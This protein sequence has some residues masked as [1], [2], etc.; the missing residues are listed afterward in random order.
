MRQNRYEGGST[1]QQRTALETVERAARDRLNRMRMHANQPAIRDSEKIPMLYVVLEALRHAQEPMRTHA[2]RA[3]EH[4][5]V[6]FCVSMPIKVLFA[7]TLTTLNPWDNSPKPV[8]IVIAAIRQISTWK[9]ADE[10]DL[11]N[12]G[13]LEYKKLD[14]NKRPKISH[15]PF[16]QR[17]VEK[18]DVLDGVIDSYNVTVD[19]HW[20]DGDV[21]VDFSPELDDQ[22]EWNSSDESTVVQTPQENMFGPQS[23]PN[24]ISSLDIE[25]AGTTTNELAPPVGDGGLTGR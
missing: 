9:F 18:V 21:T 12:L 23:D 1:G 13:I 14:K 25:Q 24:R 15:R 5:L 2:L 10:P 16:A 11:N 8:P 3:M 19:K 20:Q 17:P 4:H 6:E 22:G 7:Q